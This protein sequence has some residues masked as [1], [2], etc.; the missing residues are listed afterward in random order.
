[1]SDLASAIGALSNTGL[2]YYAVSQGQPLSVS[3]SVVGGVPVSTS[4]VGALITPGSISSTTIFLLAIAAV[5]LYFLF[6]RSG[7]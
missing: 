7:A 6:R 1:M 2:E 3:Q 4:S 5:A